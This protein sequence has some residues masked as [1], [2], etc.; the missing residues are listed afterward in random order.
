MIRRILSNVIETTFPQHG[1]NVFY[2]NPFTCSETIPFGWLSSVTPCFPIKSSNISILTDPHQFYDILLRFGA[3]AGER[4]TL[5]SLYLGNGK[6]E[7]K[8]VEVILNNPNFKQ[9]SLKVN[10]LMDYTRGSR[11]ADNSR[12][13][14]LPL[15]KENSENCEI[16]LYHTPE[17]RGLMK[18]VVPDRWNELF[19]LQHMKLYIFDDTLI[20]S[21]ANLS[22]DYFTNR[23]D[24]YF[25]IRD[26]N[27]VIFTMV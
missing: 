12:T 11:F 9:S 8:F 2:Q 1:E 19:G 26:K 24:R 17:L 13:T 25:I 20:I 21:G 4:I 22:N 3:N 6:L 7:K 5:A 16:S 23:Q 14:L 10:I 18:K 15:L 27:Y